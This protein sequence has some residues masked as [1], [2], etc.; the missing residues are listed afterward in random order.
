MDQSTGLSRFLSWVDERVRLHTITPFSPLYDMCGWTL[1]ST[2]NPSQNV[3][4]KFFLGW[5]D[6]HLH[7]M[8]R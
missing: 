2:Q 1:V 7:D 6:W 5:L 3:I 4:V 8:V